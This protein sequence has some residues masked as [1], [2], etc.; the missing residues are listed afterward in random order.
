MI[1]FVWNSSNHGES[2]FI[3]YEKGKNRG[4][5]CYLCFRSQSLTN[6]HQATS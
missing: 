5:P 3:Q 6:M 1:I 4:V 2:E